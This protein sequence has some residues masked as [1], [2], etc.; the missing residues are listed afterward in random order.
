MI[1]SMAASLGMRGG[2]WGGTSIGG[3]GQYVGMG[4]TNPY[5]SYA[6]GFRDWGG[7]A[8]SIALQGG[9]YSSAGVGSIAAY[10][11]GGNFDWAAKGS[12]IEEPS[13][14]IAGEKGR[15][16]ILPNNLTELF[17][18]LAAMG[19]NSTGTNGGETVIIVNI[20]GEQVERIVTKRQ[21]SNLNR[22]GL[23]LH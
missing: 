6:N 16:L 23:K 12:L 19:F 7:T 15:E 20:D 13:R 21:K 4:S 5:A 11:V 10:V 3:G 9:N 2:G 18:K 8:A 17:L 1:E 22:R 14:V